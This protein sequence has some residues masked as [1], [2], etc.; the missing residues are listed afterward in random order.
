M[1]IAESLDNI[2]KNS[3]GCY[4]VPTVLIRVDYENAYVPSAFFV[5][6]YRP[7]LL[8]VIFIYST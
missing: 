3:A 5:V 7:E 1:I 2:E 4:V 8:V 6:P